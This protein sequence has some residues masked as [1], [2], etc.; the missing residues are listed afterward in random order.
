VLLRWRFQDLYT[1]NCVFI[2]DEYG[3]IFA[4]YVINSLVFD[5]ELIR[6]DEIKGLLSKEFEMKDMG[7]LRYFLIIQVH[8]DRAART[9][10]INQIVSMDKIMYRFGMG[11]S[12]P[13]M[14][15]IE[16]ST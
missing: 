1:D 5:K 9:I 3:I 7:E 8:R 4:I 14:T 12:K 10:Y 2:H 11:N 13:T 15:P 6:I 16:T